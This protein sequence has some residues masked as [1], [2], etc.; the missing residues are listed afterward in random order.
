MK[1]KNHHI[2]PK[3]ENRFWGNDITDILITIVMAALFCG[4]IVTYWR[5]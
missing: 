4:M 3:K 5:I 1:P 2:P